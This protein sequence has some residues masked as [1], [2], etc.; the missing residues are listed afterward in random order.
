MTK[1]ILKVGAVMGVLGAIVHHALNVSVAIIGIGAMA[2]GLL[3]AVVV[4][5]AVS[6]KRDDDDK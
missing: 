5:A 1:A 2:I 6:L 4:A 3:V